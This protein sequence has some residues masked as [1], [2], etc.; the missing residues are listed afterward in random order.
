MR[1]TSALKITSISNIRANGNTG[2]T[3]STANGSGS[4]SGDATPRA[5]FPP[6]LSAEAAAQ[7]ERETGVPSTEP[8]WPEVDEESLSDTATV[9]AGGA[10]TP[11][12][13]ET[14][15]PAIGSWATTAT[16]TATATTAA[17]AATA[18]TATAAA[19]PSGMYWSRAP[20]FGHG[21]HRLRAHTATLVGSQIFVFGGTGANVCFNDVYVLDAD[22]MHWSKPE[23]SGEVPPV[24]R[25]MT[26]T[27]V[28]KK[29][30]IFGGGD[31]PV[32]YNDVYVFDTVTRRFTKPKVAGHV[33]GGN[34]RSSAAANGGGG[35]GSGS[36]V[37]VGGG[38]GSSGGDG[39]SESNADADAAGSG[40]GGGDGS[41]AP[42]LPQERRAH[43]ACLYK[44]GIYIFGGGNGVNALNDIWRLDVA[45]TAKP[46]WR[47]VCPAGRPSARQPPVRGYHTANMVGSKLIVFGGSDGLE[48][49]RDV[50][51]Y[52]IDTSVWRAVKMFDAPSP[53]PPPPP[54]LLPLPLSSGGAATVAAAAAAAATAGGVAAGAGMG[55]G[56]VTATATAVVPGPAGAGGSYQRLSH[57]ATVIGSYLFVIGGHDGHAYNNDVLLLNLVTMQWDRRR[58]YGT[59]PSGRGY[60]TAVLHDSRLFVI[61]GFDG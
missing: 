40:G 12:E 10:G 56:A 26:A 18:A 11:V 37:G 49:F 19:P 3:P 14:G 13:P 31:G 17:A 47:L 22:C 8:P 48:C 24:L 39:I 38:S 43:T 54:S 29:I 59:P 52:D 58:V 50:W 28:G 25:A 7:H 1:S 32:Y 27:A 21:P 34:G 51:V 4:T 36:A 35:S 46:S 33:G 57:S 53:P 61:G 15:T 60:H 5:Q 9:V 23:C 41:S 45:D 6:P 44:H 55:T 42:Q 2:T 30:V 20:C 16:L